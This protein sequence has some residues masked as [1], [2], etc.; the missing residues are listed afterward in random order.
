MSILY[1][2]IAQRYGEVFGGQ[3]RMLFA[4][5]D[6]FIELNTEQHFLVRENSIITKILEKKGIGITTQ[7]FSRLFLKFQLKEINR[8][9][10][11]RRI[12]KVFCFDS[13][14]NRIGGALKKRKPELKLYA[15]R[16]DVY[17]SPFMTSN[18]RRKKKLY[19]KLDIKTFS[20]FERV[21]C[22]SDEIFDELKDIP[23]DKLVMFNPGISEE[24][25]YKGPQ[26]SSEKTILISAG[27]F[28]DEKKGFSVLI[29]AIKILRKKEVV[30]F[31]L[32]IAGDGPDKKKFIELAGELIEEGFIEF[33]GFVENPAKLFSH[34]DIFILSS[35]YEGFPFVI[36]EAAANECAIIAT[37]IQELVKY[38]KDGKDILFFKYGNAETLSRKL[39]SLLNN[40]GK[41][42]QLS[43]SASKI[44]KQF[45]MEKSLEKIIMT[46]KL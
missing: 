33:P 41:T 31:K 28:E 23:K 4:L 35:F 15:F 39:E 32:I 7:R 27:R 30:N 12:E 1:I 24:L 13:F 42:N 29:E 36:L 2:D 26:Q 10:E 40:K 19:K 18:L 38:F 22:I 5:V 43:D 34:A 46:L 8:I 11:E 45:K 6:K 44:V 9:I 17:E 25:I 37:P 3:E 14:A 20:L 21:F 16:F